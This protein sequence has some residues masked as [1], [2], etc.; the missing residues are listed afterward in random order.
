MSETLFIRLGSQEQDPIQWLIWSTP[1][2]EI[3]ASGELNH[4]SELSH[5]TEKSHQRQVIGFVPCSDV[6]I[7]SLKVPGS[8]SR[9]ITA[10]AP[11]MLEDDLAQEVESLFF[12]FSHNVKDE[13]EK[14]SF[15]AAVEREQLIQWQSWFSD[16]GIKCKTL[17]PDALGMP[18][19]DNEWSA[20]SLNKQ[21]LIRQSQWKAWLIDEAMW[22]L[23][24][25]TWK[26]P[27]NSPVKLDIEDEKNEEVNN[28][29]S[30]E[31]DEVNN[32]VINAYST[33]PE[34]TNAT[35]QKMPEEL[36]LALLA[37]H[38][39]T[40]LINLLQGEFQVKEQRSS[41]YRNW[42]WVAGIAACA[43][44]VNV[45]LKS[46]QLIQLNGAVDSLESDII[47]TYKKAF[48]E[49]KRVRVST[50]KS[51]LKRKLS[52]VGGVSDQASFLTMLNSIQP[53]FKLVSELKPDSIKFDAKRQEI[54]LNATSTDYQSF[55]KFKIEL[56]KSDF[57]VSQGA[58]N[59]LGEQVSGSFI[60]S[61][62][63]RK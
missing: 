54:R 29:E 39:D 13:K 16:A 15:I 62:K 52:E 46:T 21:V 40:K 22:P 41:N 26:N 27:V 45:G 57:K 6:A 25:K 50:I 2:N 32:L 49:T 37:Q 51:Q 35:I 8:S 63:G 20:I 48:P 53:A 61:A 11:Y 17:I 33:L 23:I 58:Q 47:S 36:P 31:V 24:S 56:E 28:N 34:T 38:V 14:N 30:D 44:L 12:A 19:T 43:L 10:A 1:T 3:I 59:N 55:E 7:K 9:A 60:I 5:L 4:A 18:F 42:L